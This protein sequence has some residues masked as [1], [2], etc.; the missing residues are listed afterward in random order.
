MNRT[1]SDAISPRALSSLSL[2]VWTKI[3]RSYSSASSMC[4][5]CALLD[6][7]RVTVV[8]RSLSV[9]SAFLSALFI[10]FLASF[11]A[12]VFTAVSWARAAG[13]R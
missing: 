13:A 3:L 7:T 9:P 6:S 12:C 8:C 10:C 4:E 1:E 2:E 5:N 11:T